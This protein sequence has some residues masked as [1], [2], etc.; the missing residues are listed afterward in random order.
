MSEL[1][2]GEAERFMIAA[3]LAEVGTYQITEALRL[4]GITVTKGTD[5]TGQTVY[6]YQKSDGTLVA[7]GSATEEKILATWKSGIGR[8]VKA[9]MNLLLGA[10]NVSFPEST[11]ATGRTTRGA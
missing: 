8:V 5:E 6:R 3:R 2:L 7:V 1:D 4:L 10:N 9:H 11:A